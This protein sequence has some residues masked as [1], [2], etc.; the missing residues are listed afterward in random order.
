M[1]NPRLDGAH[2]GARLD[3]LG[4]ITELSTEAQDDVVSAP[5]SQ[6]YN[7]LD[8]CQIIPSVYYFQLC[9]SNYST[10]G[11]GAHVK[12]IS[13]T[14]VTVSCPQVQYSSC[15]WK[16]SKCILSQTKKYSCI[17]CT[18]KY[19]LLKTVLAKNCFLTCRCII[20]R[21]VKLRI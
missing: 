12:T 3:R 7:G 8:T 18:T 6:I 9:I 2:E 10:S 14:A 5:C 17:N 16:M 11:L 20:Q 1:A 21:Q 15:T 4:E 13:C 19:L